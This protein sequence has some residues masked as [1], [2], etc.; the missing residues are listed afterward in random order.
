MSAPNFTIEISEAYKRSGYFNV[1][2]E[3]ELEANLVGEICVCGG[4]WVYEPNYQAPEYPLTLSDLMNIAAKINELGQ[5]NE[6]E[7]SQ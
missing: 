7:V 6:S 3:S 4:Q 2:L 1:Y 5:Q